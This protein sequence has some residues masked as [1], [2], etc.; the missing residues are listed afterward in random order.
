[1]RA[2]MLV[3]AR[4]VREIVEGR[5]VETDSGSS[6]KEFKEGQ[7]IEGADAELQVALGHAEVIE[8]TPEEAKQEV[9]EAKKAEVKDAKASRASKGSKAAKA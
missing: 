9:A 4:V 7:V 8:P 6:L 5:P 2:K 3:D 1:M